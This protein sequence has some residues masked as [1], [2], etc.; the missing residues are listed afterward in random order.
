VDGIW[1][2]K[3]GTSWKRNGHASARTSTAPRA[4]TRTTTPRRPAPCWASSRSWSDTRA[5]RTWCTFSKACRRPPRPTSWPA[6]ARPPGPLP[7]RAT[8]V[9]RCRWPPA[10]CTAPPSRWAPSTRAPPPGP[11][12][13]QALNPRRPPPGAVRRQFLNLCVG[14]VSKGEVGTVRRKGS[15][16]CGVR[17]IT[18]YWIWSC[19]FSSFG[20]REVVAPA[21]V[22]IHSGTV[23]HTFHCALIFGSNGRNSVSLP[24]SNMVSVD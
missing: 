2:L 13:R 5:R 11:F 6:R 23:N 19:L 3:Q 1:E 21:T 17:Y 24:P 15:R 10:A 22:A 9:R 4:R 12:P 18:C 14:S 16:L 8:P 7:R 20:R